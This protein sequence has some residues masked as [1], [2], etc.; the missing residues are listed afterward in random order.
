MKHENRP[1]RIGTL[2]AARITPN[3][4]IKPTRV[5]ENAEV[6]AV[7]ARDKTRA[8][9][10]ASKYDIPTVHASYEALIADPDIDAIYNPLPNSLHAEW[11]IRALRAGKH[12]LCEKPFA[13][14]A[15]EA[16]EMNRV[17]ADT[18][19]ILI[20][21]FHNLYHPLTQKLKA[22][23]T[24]GELGSI[25]HVEAHFNMPIPKFKDIR[26]A[27][28]LAGGATMD[29][30]CYPI[31]LLRYL[32]DEEPEVVGAKAVLHSDQID[33]RM[34]AELTFPNGITGKI[35]CA[36]F[37]PWRMNIQLKVQGSD[38]YIRAINPWLPHYF[39]WL[40]T[41]SPRRRS[42][43]MVSGYSTYQYQ[44]EAF[45]KLIKE[46]TAMFTDAEFGIRN[47]AVIDAIYEKAGLA[48]RGR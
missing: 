38:G 15:T 35:S 16:K 41:K 22:I 18:G 19:F 11:S 6:V 34:I 1:I 4:L 20:E 27:Y 39:N 36:L 33:Q 25:Q 29:V 9:Q 5:M 21:A 32:L 44:L 40:S 7:A 43:G 31:G 13:S 26:L 2:G 48:V 30:G 23:I 17:A 12:V 37:L 45:V 47:M 42:N 8:Q 3:A 10:F 24:S 14:N 46:G 28:D